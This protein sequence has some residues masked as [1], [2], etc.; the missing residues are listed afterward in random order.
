M[1][2]TTWEYVIRN[3]PLN[4]KETKKIQV[5]IAFDLVQVLLQKYVQFKHLAYCL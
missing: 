1:K 2:V 5:R 3:I 4:S